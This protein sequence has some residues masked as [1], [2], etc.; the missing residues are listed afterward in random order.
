ME[1]RATFS[2]ASIGVLFV[3][4]QILL[5]FTFFYWPTGAAL[6]WAFTLERPW[7]GGNEWVGLDNFRQ[8][9][10]DRAYW[11]SITRSLVFAGAT[12]FLAM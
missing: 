10:A 8:V 7:G 9:F 6:F 4:P 12:T 2:N 11:A 5:V 1:K 3:A